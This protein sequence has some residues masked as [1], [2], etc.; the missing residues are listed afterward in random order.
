MFQLIGHRGVRGHAPENTLRG[1]KQAFDMGCV[2][3]EF[4]VRRCK[5]GELVVIHD[6]TVDRTTNGS[7]KVEMLSLAELQ[8]FDAGGG[9]IIPTLDAVIEAAS[10]KGILFIELKETGIGEEVGHKVQHAIDE[11]A[12]ASTLVVI[13]FLPET[14]K[15][16]RSVND[17]IH[18]GLNS[19]GLS[20]QEVSD[21]LEEVRMQ[22]LNPYMKDVD[23]EFVALAQKHNQTI[24]TWT[25]NDANDFKYVYDLGLDFIF[26]D[27]PDRLIG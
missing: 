19:E 26:T 24:G 10:P 23:G 25:V 3:V 13:S 4:D 1:F 17:A 2:G 12:D 14:L 27:Y 20:V 5:T 7:G 8:S 16:V 15:E 21:V 6:E 22:H 11:G 9:A 18:I